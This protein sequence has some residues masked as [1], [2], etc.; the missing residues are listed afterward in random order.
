MVYGGMANQPIQIPPGSLIFNNISVRGFWLTGG[1][2]EMK[3]GWKSKERLVDR[4]VALFRQKAIRPVMYVPVALSWSRVLI[5][6]KRSCSHVI[7]C[8]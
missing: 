6:M 4:V 8:K 5:V 1:Y 3:E 2:A 7:L